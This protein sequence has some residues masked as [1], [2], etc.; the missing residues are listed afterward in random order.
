[1]SG[2]FP[3]LAGCFLPIVAWETGSSRER[4]AC[5]AVGWLGAL[6]SRFSPRPFLGTVPRSM[7][8]STTVSSILRNP[9]YTV[10]SHRVGPCSSPPVPRE[11]GPQVLHPRYV[12]APAPPCTPAIQA[13][14]DIKPP[15]R[16]EAPG[17]R[18]PCPAGK[19]LVSATLGPRGSGSPMWSLKRYLR[20]DDSD[21]SQSFVAHGSGTVL[22][23]L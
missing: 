10:R 2:T 22:R 20:R 15:G 1:M 21:G 19:G 14:L 17:Q 13:H 3:S 23:P 7:T 16:R 6:G 12:K 11:V 9:I 5:T 18:F 4:K 8:P